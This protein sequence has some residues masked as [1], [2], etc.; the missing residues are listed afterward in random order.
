M[1]RLRGRGTRPRRATVAAS[2]AAAAA[3][4]LLLLAP[5]T[6]GAFT[7][8]ITNSNNS[9]ASSAT[10]FSCMNAVTADKASAL[11]A[12]P[13]NEAT[14][15]G[16]AVD[17]DSGA[18]PGTYRGGM[19]STNV[20]P[21]ACLRDSGGSYQLNGSSSQVTNGLQ[22]TSPQTFSTEVWF[23]TTVRGGKL[24]GFGNSQTGLSG[25]YDRH[26]YINTSGQLVFGTYTPQAGIMT[27]ASSAVV[28]DGAWH[29]AV[30][31]MSP[32]NGMTLYLDGKQAAAN[33]SFRA[34]EGTTGWWRIGYDNLDT[35]P[36]AGNRYFAGSMRFAAV[37]SA[38]LTPT[39]VL[40]HYNAGR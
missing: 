40:D 37:Y 17:I 32:T 11:F 27:I 14:G 30:A 7:A 1:R 33:S 13:L 15:S 22:Q 5:T 31:T 36:G 25:S 26:T 21:Q 2:L 12:Y 24:I 20:S 10:Y 6:N 16:Q 34:S 19:T 9:A 39:Q 28:T 18:Y 4:M 38:A 29:H 3:G 35:W 8:A 23:K